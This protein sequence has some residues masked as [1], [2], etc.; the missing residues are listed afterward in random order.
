[1]TWLKDIFV[2]KSN[3]EMEREQLLYQLREAQNATME[4][5]NL[6]SQENGNGQIDAQQIQYLNNLNASVGGFLQRLRQR[7]D[8]ETV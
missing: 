6:L 8:R 7:I 4:M 2:N 1:M 5:G 3:E